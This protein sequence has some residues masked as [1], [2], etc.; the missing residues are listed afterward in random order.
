MSGEGSITRFGVLGTGRIT[1]RLV[2]DIQS[3]DGAE[4]TA[5]ASRTSERARWQADQFGIAAA[6]EGYESLLVRDDVDAVYVALPPSMHAEWAIAAAKAGKHVLCEKPLTVSTKQSLAVHLACQAHSVRLLDA[7]GWL[8]HERT[9]MFRRWLD[10]GRFGKIGHI[11]AAVSF[12]RPFI[13]GE[14]RLD[15]ALGGGCLL[16]LGWYVCSLARF[17]AGGLPN[18]VVAGRVMRQGVA[19]RITAMMW[20]DHDVTA[21]LSCGYDTSTRKWCEVAG[22]DA[23]LVCDDFTRPWHD[24]PA[25][26]WIHD[27]TGGVEQFPFEGNQERRMIARFIS[28]E[29]LD[30]YQQQALDTQH[31]IDAINE[32]VEFDHDEL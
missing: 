2:A 22:S 17:V 28:D 26:C 15:P 19:Q 31:M 16:D 1:R 8:H 29:P 25:R 32:S 4:V 5:I 27:A 24:R 11:T 21:T 9:E 10:E 7:T 13:T 18:R 20:F 30:V 23:S 3:T 6:V 12:F 14:H